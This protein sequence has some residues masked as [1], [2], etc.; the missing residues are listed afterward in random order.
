M[1]KGWFFMTDKEKL[2][3]YNYVVDILEAYVDHVQS[4]RD[5]GH[6][7]QEG[8]GRLAQSDWILQL[9]KP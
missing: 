5:S 4:L 2:E 1:A 6:L 9:L 7:S 8:T 3:K